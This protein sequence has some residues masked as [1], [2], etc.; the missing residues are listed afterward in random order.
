MGESLVPAQEHDM[1]LG[2]L[3]GLGYG[4]RLLCFLFHQGLCYKP[5]G[6]LL[7][8]NIRAFHGAAHS[9]P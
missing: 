6:N 5:V 9:I 3:S 7:G 2:T 8:D 4:R 1:G